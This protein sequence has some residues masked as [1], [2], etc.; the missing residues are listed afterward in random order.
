[1]CP[2]LWQDVAEVRPRDGDARIAWLL[3]RRRFRQAFAIAETDRTLVLL[4]YEQ[5]RLPVSQASES[6]EQTTGQIRIPMCVC[7]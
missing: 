7:Y 2:L 1:M 4:D 5:A 3:E 6:C